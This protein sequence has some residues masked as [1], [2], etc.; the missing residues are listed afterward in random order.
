MDS[1]IKP[2]TALY[3]FMQWAFFPVVLVATPWLLFV[4]IS[5]GGSVAITTYVVAVAVGLVFWL[6]EWLMP[7]LLYTSPS[8][9]DQRGSRMPSSA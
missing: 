7:C 8:P 5:A 6:A 2:N 3:H 1:I 4:L 9:R